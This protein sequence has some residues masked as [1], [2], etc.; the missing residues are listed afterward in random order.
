MKRHHKHAVRGAPSAWVA[1]FAPLIANGGRVLDV[2]CGAG[3]H[4]ALLLSL[5]YRVDAVDRRVAG[6]DDLRGRTGLHIVEADLETAGAP[7]FPADEYDGIVV[8]NYLYRAL[9]PT[10]ATRLAPGGVVI[11]ETFAAGNE[12]FGKPNNPNYLLNPGELLAAFGPP[13]RVL[14][15]ED[16]TV[17][18]PQPAAIQRICAQN[19]PL[20]AP[21]PEND[22]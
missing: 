6:L 3:R 9:L 7:P 4:T 18:E 1:R 14:A 8:T 13:L 15:Y 10:L 12:R 11:Y 22:G 19:P 5:G 20:D 21:H 17:A 16:L 2:A